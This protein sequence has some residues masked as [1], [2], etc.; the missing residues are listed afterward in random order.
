MIGTPPCLRSWEYARALAVS[1]YIGDEIYSLSVVGP[2]KRIRNKHENYI[3]RL[4]EIKT[5]LEL[6]SI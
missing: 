6:E 1:F 3:A 4:L 2:I 5:Q